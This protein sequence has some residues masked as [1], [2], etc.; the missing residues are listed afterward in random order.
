MTAISTGDSFTDGSLDT[1][2]TAPY[3]A[4]Q[5]LGGPASP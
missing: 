1:L 2:L 4:G 3:H 5:T